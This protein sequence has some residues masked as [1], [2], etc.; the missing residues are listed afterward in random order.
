MSIF[1]PKLDKK[2][3]I[4]NQNTFAGVRAGVR[5]HR[6]S[7]STQSQVSQEKK[8]RFIAF[9]V[10]VLDFLDDTPSKSTFFPVSP[11]TLKRPTPPPTTDFRAI[12]RDFLGEFVRYVKTFYR[13]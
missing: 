1:K 12:F 10:N 2:A 7:K 3:D 4:S 13:L 9:L 8:I 5:T 11:P 6:Y